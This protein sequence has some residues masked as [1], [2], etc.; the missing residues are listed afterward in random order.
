MVARGRASTARADVAYPLGVDARIEAL[1]A[2]LSPSLRALVDAAITA[3]ASRGDDAASRTAASEAAS[4]L[5]VAAGFAAHA[6]HAIPL[7]SE[8]TNDQRR[9]YEIVAR[10]E[11]PAFSHPF[12]GNSRAILRWLGLAPPSPLEELVEHAGREVPLWRALAEMDRS[13]D[14]TRPPPATPEAHR[15]A[16]RAR[17]ALLDAMPHERALRTIDCLL[18]FERSPYAFAPFHFFW[19]GEHGAGAAVLAALRGEGA[20]WA[21]EQLEARAAILESDTVAVIEA[22]RALLWLFALVRAGVAIEPRWD[23]ALVYA[24]PHLAPPSMFV[25]CALAI[26][27][28][29]R[30]RAVVAAMQATGHGIAGNK[31]AAGLALL[32]AFDSRAIAAAMIEAVKSGIRQPALEEKLDALATTRPGVRRALID[33]QATLAKPL[34]LKVKARLHPIDEAALSPA[35]AAQLAALR[36]SDPDD[37]GDPEMIGD[38]ELRTLTDAKGEHVFDFWLFASDSGA[39]FEAGT[40]REVAHR[41]QGFVELALSQPADASLLAGLRKV[42]ETKLPK[43]KATKATK[44]KAT[45]TKATVKKTTT[46]PTPKPKSSR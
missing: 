25:E 28:D 2:E 29:R 38:L 19:G 26:P 21:R 8:L 36:Q 42:L 44:T 24:V 17:V 9:V 40:T 7:P 31:L 46:K 34:A 27:E 6:K 1:R 15:A 16:L 11:L 3:A 37:F 35:H 10:A 23:R 43:A 14:P 5:L 30:E 4:A 13:R 20:A 12:G 41:I 18:S 39:V 33:W 45:K 22:E 32:E